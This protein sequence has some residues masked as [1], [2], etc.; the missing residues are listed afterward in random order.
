M[1]LLLWLSCPRASRYTCAA[2]PPPQPDQ[3]Q[4]AQVHSH[5][6]HLPRVARRM[7]FACTTLKDTECG[8]SF[9]GIA[10]Y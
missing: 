8:T 4:E 9:L 5:N 6:G 1:P 3:M 10:C 7:A 2:P